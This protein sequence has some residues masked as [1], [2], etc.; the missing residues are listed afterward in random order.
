MSLLLKNAL[1]ADS[2]SPQNNK[3]TSIL[4]EKGIIK[5]FGSGRSGEEIDL[6]G[7]LVTVGWFDLNANFN[8]PGK[9]YKEDIVSGSQAALHGG[10][11]DVNLSPDTTPPVQSKSSVEY[12]LGKSSNNIDLHVS[13]SLSEDLKGENLTEILDL[14]NAGAASFSEGDDP[15]WN[16]ELLMK[17]LQ[18]T[19]SVGTPIFQ[20]AR[21][22]HISSN[23]HMHEGRVSVNLGL[24]GEPSLSEE[25]IIQRDLE[26]L[27]YVGGR[28]HFSRISTVK[29]VDLIKQA[30]KEDIKVTCDV[31]IHHLLFTDEQVSEFDTIFKSLPPYRSEKD[32]GALIRGLKEGTIDA[33]CSNH[34][35][36]D[37]ENK[38]LEFD[39]AEPGS[40]SLQ[41]FYPSLL[42]ISKEVPMDILLD[43]ITN[44]PRRVLGLGSLEINV[45]AIAKL[46][47]LDPQNEWILNETSNLSKSN[48]SPFWNQKL[49]GKVAG[50]VNGEAY[51]LF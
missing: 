5:S 23:A 46:T 3:K 24:R 20:N 16:G 41:T 50:T 49:T 34:R 22:L 30:K 35:P 44:G 11:T 10:F 2:K 36:Q 6:E 17:A 14:N 15:V 43:R 47:I 9:E 27:R 8:D 31:G 51:S 42:K 21:D 1:I 45:G 25:L 7:K 48:N 33:I 29:A 28:L 32:R 12:L 26:I 37:M 18:Y 4:I 19:E 40:I 13:A 39:L 38:Q